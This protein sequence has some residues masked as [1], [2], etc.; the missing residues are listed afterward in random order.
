MYYDYFTYD[1]YRGASKGKT[2]TVPAALDKVPL[3]IRGGSIIPTR[4]RPRRSS[5]LMK[6][7]PFTLRVA[8]GTRGSA[9]GELYLDDGETFSHRDGKFIWREFSVSKEN[10]GIRIQSADLAAQKPGEAVDGVALSTYSS[11]NDFAKDIA[12]VRVERVVVLGLG[13]NPKSVQAGG[14]E[15]HWEYNPGLS[16]DTKKQGAASVLVIKDPGVGVSSDWEIVI[17]V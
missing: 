5:V 3:F 6:N 14:K 1:E 10:K 11:A 2:V 16:S 4:E 7:D 12:S 9:R 15:L 17:Q 13:A 8:L